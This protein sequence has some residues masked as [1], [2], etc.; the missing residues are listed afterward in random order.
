MKGFE[1][2]GETCYFNTALQCLMCIPVLTNHFIRYPYDGECTFTREY[3]KLVRIYWKRGE[4]KVD[5][6]PIISQFR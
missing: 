5:V 2:F 1:N 4:H 6:G 3:S